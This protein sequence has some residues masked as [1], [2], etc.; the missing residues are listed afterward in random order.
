[1]KNALCLMLMLAGAIWA[2]DVHAAATL[3][4]EYDADGNMIRGEGKYYEYNDANQLVRVRNDNA[5]GAIIAEYFYDYNG[6]R[7]KKVENGVTTYYIGKHYEKQFA[8]NSQSSTDYYF[9]N[10]ERVAKKE[11]T[12]KL[13]YFHS[14]HLGGTNATTDAAGNLVERTKYYPFGEMREGGSE[15]Y[16][17]T[18]K[19]KDKQT[20]WYYYEARFY[21]PQIMHFTQADTIMPNPY[22]PQNY[23][24]YAY[25]Q[26]NPIKFIDPSGHSAWDTVKSTA[27]SAWTGVKNIS[28]AVVNIVVDNVAKGYE[29]LAEKHD[30]TKAEQIVGKASS[31]ISTVDNIKTGVESVSDQIEYND[32]ANN[33]SL[34][35]DTIKDGSK[36]LRAIENIGANL[37]SGLS[38]GGAGALGNHPVTNSTMFQGMT[39]TD[40]MMNHPELWNQYEASHTSVSRPGFVKWLKENGYTE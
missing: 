7:I 22:N 32:K 39:A 38:P 16:S 30:L 15:K 4:Y 28:S 24:K 11:S 13:T 9:A 37:G 6:Q 35:S 21:N 8:G 29:A 12:G 40:I 17:Y 20:D 3:T 34:A 19:E 2:T 18:G 1:M 31:A 23:N 10:G 36:S 5:A 27:T 33:Q 25:T 14:D 26:N